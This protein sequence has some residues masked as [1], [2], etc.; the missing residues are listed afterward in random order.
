MRCE[1]HFKLMEHDRLEDGPKMAYHLLEHSQEAGVES[2]VPFQ[3]LRF[4]N[5]RMPV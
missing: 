4:A 2:L 1:T 5:R 3:E